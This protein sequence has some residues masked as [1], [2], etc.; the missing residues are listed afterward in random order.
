[1]ADKKMRLIVTIPAYNE[2][3]NIEA[4]IKEIPR[5]ISGITD[6]KVLVLDDGSRDRT[7]E[8]AKTAGADYVISHKQNKGLAATFQD[9]MAAALE[10]GADIVV[11]TDGD[12]HYNQSRIPDLIRPILDQRADIVIGDREIRKLE[13]MPAANKYLNL[14]GSY[15]VSR[16]IGVKKTLDVSSGFRAYTREAVMR[17][18]IL[19]RHTYTHE[20]LIQ[21]VD[22][23]LIVTSV[24]IM[25]R[26][27][28]RKSRLIKS[29]PKHLARSIFVILRV[30]TVYKPLRVLS[31]I[32]S[33]II[34]PGII[35]VI[36]FLYYFIHDIRGGDGH[37]QS[38]I[39]AAILILVGF[40]VLVLALIASAIGW[41]RK[42]LEEILYR[43]KKNTLQ[44]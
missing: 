28:T 21:A 31:F 19:S 5:V 24:P 33:L 9:A 35:L 44:K 43:S 7:V 40:Q 39:I 27:V 38:L 20:T 13:Y 22:N 14:M 41:N 3:E 32:G 26:K 36:R 10:R 18:S 11:N 25:A 17:I 42:T 8:L 4:V 1:L 15:F 29:I 30:F 16:L 23:N 12:N 34:I 2:E 6:V 37:I